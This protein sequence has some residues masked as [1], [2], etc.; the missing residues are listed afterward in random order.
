MHTI[1]IPELEGFFTHASVCALWTG[2][3]CIDKYPQKNFGIHALVPKPCGTVFFLGGIFM[4]IHV[5]RNI[6][7][8]PTC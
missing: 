4:Y 2:A 5:L 6:A 3:L 8:I 1:T 7:A